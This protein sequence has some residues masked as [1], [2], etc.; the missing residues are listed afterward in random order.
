MNHTVNGP[1]RRTIQEYLYGA[2][3]EP[4]RRPPFSSPVA[5]VTRPESRA[6]VAISRE[7]R[8]RGRQ[9]FEAAL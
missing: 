5:S 6:A 9:A 4:M 3:V 8:Q 7:R 1:I 2:S